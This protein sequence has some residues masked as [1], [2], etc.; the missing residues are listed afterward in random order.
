ML[1]FE[2]ERV[3]KGSEWYKEHR[4][5]MLDTGGNT[6][7]FNLGNPQARQFATDFISE[8]ITEFGL[9]C[10]RQDFNMEP[11]PYWHAAD[12]PDRQGIAETRHIEGL[13]AF[14]DELLKRHPN[15]SLTTAP[16]ADGALTWRPLAAR[17]PTGARTD[18]ATPSP[19][20]ATPTA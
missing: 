12:A 9:G 7:L 4:D 1:W 19:T 13:Y 11:L 20:N 5:W 8:R 2:P 15:L 17:P 16:P 10:Y 6:V 14:W 18:R 3:M